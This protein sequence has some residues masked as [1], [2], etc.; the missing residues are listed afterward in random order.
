MK[1][2]TVL[3]T[4]DEIAAFLKVHHSFTS[5]EEEVSRFERMKALSND[6]RSVLIIYDKTD[7]PPLASCIGYSGDVSGLNGTLPAEQVRGRAIVSHEMQ[8]PLHP[9]IVYDLVHKGISEINQAIDLALAFDIFAYALKASR[10]RENCDIVAGANVDKVHQIWPNAALIIVGVD[11]EKV[12]SFSVTAYDDQT[13]DN[14]TPYEV[15][16]KI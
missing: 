9:R 6:V 7:S 11:D 2:L 15:L 12:A 3:K 16:F 1:D 10:R 8:G 5:G 4:A 13:D 14:A